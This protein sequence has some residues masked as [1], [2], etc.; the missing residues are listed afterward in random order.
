[1]KHLRSDEAASLEMSKN[2]TGQDAFPQQVGEIHTSSDNA[3]ESNVQLCDKLSTAV[4]TS[5]LKIEP[6]DETSPQATGNCVNVDNGSAQLAASSSND[7]CM[8]SISL[9]VAED[10][11]PN[12]TTKNA[13]GRNRFDKLPLGEA[14]CHQK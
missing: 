13:S 9:A 5:G 3:A 10:C 6:A 11:A 4:N 2:R 7:L 14:E 8:N 12:E 1:M